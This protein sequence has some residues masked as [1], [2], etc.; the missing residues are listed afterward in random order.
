MRFV[1]PMPN[2]SQAD[3]VLGTIGPRRQD[4][5]FYA[6]EVGDTILGQLGLGGRIGL[7]VRDNAGMAYYARTN[8]SGN[9]GPSP[10][11][12]YA[13]VNP[14]GVDKAIE[15]IL[16]EI[17]RFREELVADQELVDAKAYLT[18]TLPLQLETN[19]GVASML[20]EMQL[21]QLGDDFIARYPEL[22]N[23]V[24]KQE[25]R[26]AAQKYLSDEHYAL[27]IAGPYP[28]SKPTEAKN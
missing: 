20:L 8:L 13:G 17:R 25:I 21:Y 9:L 1:H 23:A 15:L 10:W 12:A 5:D 19:E 3:L 6:A 24:T 18:G 16:A 27:A 11:S 4:A 7:S 22:I 28:Q 2:K 26:A 14:A